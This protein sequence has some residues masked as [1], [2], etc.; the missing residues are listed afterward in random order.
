MGFT[1]KKNGSVSKKE[2]M[3]SKFSHSSKREAISQFWL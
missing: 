3:E 2:S 1:N